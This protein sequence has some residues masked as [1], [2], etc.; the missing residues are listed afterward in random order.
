LLR[1]RRGRRA[2][3]QG[4]R[5]KPRGLRGRGQRAVSP[6]RRAAR[7]DVV[8]ARA[9]RGARGSRRAARVGGKRYRRGRESRGQQA[10]PAEKEDAPR[11]QLAVYRGRSALP[12]P[13]TA[14]RLHS[15]GSTWTPGT[16]SQRFST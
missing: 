15:Y 3:L 14:Y 2:V 4:R 1:D 9:D 5:R 13:P 8:L 16:L 11:R 10:A 12:A 6:R 7:L